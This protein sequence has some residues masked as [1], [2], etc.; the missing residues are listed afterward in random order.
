MTI[1]LWVVLVLLGTSAI[2]HIGRI[3]GSE[4]FLIPNRLALVGDLVVDVAMISWTSV[5]LFGAK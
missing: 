3:Y 5:L 4:H 1:Y 2:A